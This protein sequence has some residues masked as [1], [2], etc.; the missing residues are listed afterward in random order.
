MQCLLMKATNKEFILLLKIIF[1]WI[2]GLKDLGEDGSQRK[3]K[4]CLCILG[5]QAG[6]V[7]VLEALFTGRQSL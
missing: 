4:K 5:V 7:F 1:A 2:N 6:D 3:S